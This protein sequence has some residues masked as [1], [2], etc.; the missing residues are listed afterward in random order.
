M[1]T[2]KEKSSEAKGADEISN[3]EELKKRLE[4]TIEERR[5]K[6]KEA[7]AAMSAGKGRLL[8]EKPIISHDKEIT[9]LPYDF[10]ELTGIEYTEAMDGDQNAQH[11]YRITHKQALALFAT[12][13]AKQSESLDR[14]DIIERIGITDAMQGEQLATLF[15]NAST[16][17]GQFRISKR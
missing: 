12:A 8:L 14:R 1:D 4:S 3:A 10:N 11:L 17:A 6:F 16:R 15:F 13:A 5:A 7:Q 9:E 2:G